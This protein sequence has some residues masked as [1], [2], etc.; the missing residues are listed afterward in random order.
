M[1]ESVH[2]DPEI[3]THARWAHAILDV[4]D[5]LAGQCDHRSLEDLL[6]LRQIVGSY[7]LLLVELDL[8][9]PA[10]DA[11]ADAL[12]QRIAALRDPDSDH[13]GEDPAVAA[14]RIGLAVDLREATARRVRERIA[15]W[16]TRH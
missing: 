9:V 2:S 5:E 15:R 8:E 10:L 11:L 14:T 12:D 6:V 3:E 7:E 16:R 1:T 4:C 13:E